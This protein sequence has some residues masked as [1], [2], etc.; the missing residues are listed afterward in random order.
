MGTFAS[1]SKTSGERR[2]VHKHL[3][4]KDLLFRGKLSAIYKFPSEKTNVCTKTL[5]ETCRPT[6][7]ETAPERTIPSQ[8]DEFTSISTKRT[9]T[10]ADEDGF[11]SLSVGLPS[12]RIYFLS[13]IY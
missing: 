10:A 1:R 9:K 12:K 2:K 13:L 11:S 7:K 4:R 8:E 6:P 3:H 5:A